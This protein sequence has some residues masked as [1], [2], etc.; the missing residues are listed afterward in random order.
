MTNGK[1]DMKPDEFDESGRRE[2]NLNAP[3]EETAPAAPAEEAQGEAARL[4]DQLLRALAEMEN[5]RRR[6]ER[7]REET[8]KYAVTGF[9]R[10]MLS[11]ADN[12][13]RAL[14]NISAE[15]RATDESLNA[16]ATGVEAT[17]RELQ[18]ILERFGVRRIDPLG[19]PFDPHFHQA[20]AE[21]PGT[22]RPPGTVA[23]VM[24]SGYVIHDRLLRPAMVMVAK[25]DPAAE[26]HVDT[27]A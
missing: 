19:Q 27:T 22:G 7:D 8:A 24:R 20:I 11:V 16:L 2:P 12:L 5:M 18:A 13:R 10:E 3:G 6:G 15:T 21:V 9:A 1:D 26:P 23:Q 4:K 25:G 17:E 14:E